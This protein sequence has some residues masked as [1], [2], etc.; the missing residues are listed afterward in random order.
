MFWNHVLGND[1]RLALVH[2]DSIGGLPAP[3]AG[4]WRK[5]NARSVQKDFVAKHLDAS[6]E[7]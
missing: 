5:S 3:A 4:P 2:H 1:R 7:G 6:G